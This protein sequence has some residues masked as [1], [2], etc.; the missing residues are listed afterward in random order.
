MRNS[1][2][3]IFNSVTLSYEEQI[4]SRRS[5]IVKYSC[6][7]LASVAMTVLYVWIYTSVLG[8][9]LPKTARLQRINDG[10][11][12]KVDLIDR[13]LDEYDEV[14]G[15]LQ[16]RDD[17]IYRS[18][19]GMSPI[20]KE[21]RNAGFGGVNRYAYLD[22][23]DISGHIKNTVVRL[24]VLTKKSYVQSKSFDDVSLVAARSGEM[25]S[26]IPKIS[27]IVPDRSQYRLSSSFGVRKDPITG[28]QARHMGLDFAIEVGN[29]VYSTGDGVVSYV[30]HSRYGYGN[31]IIVDH[32]FGYKTR[33]AHLSTTDVVE[34][35]Q[36]WRGD[37][38]GRTGNSGKSSGPHLHYEVIY[39]DRP[40]N[41]INYLDLEIPAEE[42]SS[43][44]RQVEAGS[45][46]VHS[47][48]R[49]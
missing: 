14:L 8:Q 26:C 12:A 16:M 33:Y 45:D 43:M 35:M 37:F 3:Y 31:N 19:F 21:V 20:S 28:R 6:L 34:G 30:G 10:W 38:L 7:F 1:K 48:I 17:E 41:P 27:P 24:D 40:V 9:D 36:V 18:I 42:Y 32:G 25:V 15:T 47:D 39:M 5:R 4:R 11:S 2:K 44:V 23:A 49:K 46:I 29:P 22:G 13:H